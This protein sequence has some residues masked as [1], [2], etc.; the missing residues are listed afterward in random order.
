MNLEEKLLATLNRLTKWR[1]TFAG[2]QL[3][4]RSIEDPESQ[5]VRDHREVT[6][7][8]RAE[9]NVFT[10]LLLD[11]QIFTREEFQKQL[12]DEAEHL[13]KQYEQKFPGFKSTDLG[14]EI[15]P[16]VAKETV[17]NWKP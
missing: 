14:M 13:S 4:T 2:W 7:L 10:K 6:I 11:K 12:I 1:S 8:M 16:V 17:K 15:D 3:G 5:A 9:I